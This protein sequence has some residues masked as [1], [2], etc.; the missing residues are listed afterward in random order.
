M[1]FSLAVCT[2]NRADYL[3]LT[4]S[5]LGTLRIPEGQEWELLVVNNASTDHT[6]E[7]IA[8]HAK[9]LPIRHLHMPTPGASYARNMVIDEARGDIIYWTDD[10]AMPDVDWIPQL[11][12]TF[13]Q[14]DAEVVFG[15]VSPIW[16]NGPPSWYSARFMGSF[17]LLDYG[18]EPFVVQ[19]ADHPF[20]SVNLATRRRL[21]AGLGRF[22]ED[23]GPLERKSR[24][25][26][27]TDLFLRALAAGVRMVYQ[28]GAMVGH[29]LPASRCTK[30]DL[31]RR[32]WE[33]RVTQYQDLRE[34]FAGIP[35]LFGLPRWFYRDALESAVGY[36]R[37]TFRFRQSEAL[38]YE[39]RLRRFFT[40]FYHASLLR[41]G[42][43]SDETPGGD[44]GMSARIPPPFQPRPGKPTIP[45]T[46]P[47]CTKESADAR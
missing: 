11:Y 20:F 44:R 10:D 7:V 22:R 8:K 25:G 12:R 17:A 47:A 19:D 16:E 46:D 13:Q 28:P 43:A 14:Y 2:Y 33:N 36:A 15:P 27:D 18:E 38:F 26:E 42:L 9:T 39:L 5:H 3:D 30:W 40:Q 21:F 41:A 29:N 4:L 34:R 32:I 23:L 37:S 1:D 24:L 6:D 31:R 35:W 45:A